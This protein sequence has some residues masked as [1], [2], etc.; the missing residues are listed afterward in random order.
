[1]PAGR[2]PGPYGKDGF[3]GC[4]LKP[5]PLDSAYFLKLDVPYLTP[6]PMGT[7][8]DHAAAV[9]DSTKK[10]SDPDEEELKL[11]VEAYGVVKNRQ[12]T[13]S[14]VYWKDGK[15]RYRV[16][17]YAADRDAFFGSAKAYTD[18]RDKARGELDA[19]EGK[20]RRYIEP[21]L[22]KRKSVTEWKKA[23]DVFYAWVRKAY[24]KE[25]GDKAD[26]P[27]LIKSQM[28]EKLKKALQQVKVD[29]GK[30]FQVGG[31][32]PR[33][34]KLGGYRLGTLSEHAT[35]MAIDVE[36]AKNAQIQV[37]I[38]KSILSFT[39]KSLDHEKRKSLWKTKPKELYDGI[40]EINDE[41]VSKLAK[42]LKSK[43]EAAKK[44]AAAKDATKEQKAAAAK[45]LAD[46]LAVVIKETAELK[47]I[48]ETFLKQWKNG[49]FDLPW[50]LVKELHEEGFVW[51]ATFTHP[52]LHHF[53]L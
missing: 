12:G 44:S 3:F 10:S 51:G 17:E 29:Y 25:L 42:T 8:K 30:S 40:K 34:M 15:K 5:G 13:K 21:S 43:E 11:L 20:L 48:G 18:F 28:S 23:Q 4:I 41:F 31:F 22:V 38:W 39:G 33:P 24:E 2:I 47:S 19:D 27:K 50:E 35:G 6:G 32:N 7:H 52:D 14:Y 46:P 49:F 37:S 26:I 9:A 45:V 36:S 16:K 53:E 1:M